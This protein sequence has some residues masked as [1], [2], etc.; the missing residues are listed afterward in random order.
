MLRK[1][2]GTLGIAGVIAGTALSGAA[3]ATAAA[4]ESKVYVVH[5]LG[6]QFYCGGP[7]DSGVPRCEDNYHFG[8]TNQIFVVGLDH[9]VWTIWNGG[10]G[11]SGWHSLG[12]KA[13]SY[14]WFTNQ[15]G[16]DFTINVV[17]GDGNRWSKRRYAGGSWSNWY[18]S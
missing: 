13:Y 10:G 11:W 12:G 15:H 16:S 17:G 2:V 3:P 8:H 7:Y 4:D 18:R 1:I 14:V 6:G 5:D 9:A